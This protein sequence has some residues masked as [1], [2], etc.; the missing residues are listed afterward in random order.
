VEN[1]KAFPYS[2]IERQITKIFIS[3]N[4]KLRTFISPEEIQEMAQ[5]KI[6]FGSHTVNHAILTEESEDTIDEELLQSKK[7]LEKIV[8]QTIDMIS[9]PN[10]KYSK[11]I[12]Q[13]ARSFGYKYGFTTTRG[14][15]NQKN[16]LMALPRIDSD[17]DNLND[18]S[19]KFSKYM[20][21]WE[22]R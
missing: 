16:K 10:G 12:I 17:W 8:G 2:E 13:K 1:W 6:E 5:G 7:T 4:N 19:E 11:K 3:K 9:Y 15:V 22:I 14:C 21:Q 18:S 20:F